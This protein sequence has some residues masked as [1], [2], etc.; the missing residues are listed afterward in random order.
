MKLKLS[1]VYCFVTLVGILLGAILGYSVDK[2]SIIDTFTNNS[3]TDRSLLPNSDRNF[4][5]MYSE[6]LAMETFYRLSQG[7]G[8]RENI[9]VSCQML[10]SDGSLSDD[11][12]EQAKLS[13]K[14]ISELNASLAIFHQ[15]M[16][17]LVIQHS[18]WNDSRDELTIWPYPTFAEEHL[19]AFIDRIQQI[20]GNTETYALVRDT[21][22]TRSLYGHYGNNT[23]KIRCDQTRTTVSVTR[24]ASN[25]GKKIASFDLP[26]EDIMKHTGFPP[27]LFN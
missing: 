5:A 3:R 9:Y 6:A 23:V 25:T 27:N 2:D 13:S 11:F 26:I 8:Y 16:Q 21:L 7:E 22:M 15:S 18:E 12:T 19:G 24:Y 20:L 1:R 4:G 10:D 14:E 17:E